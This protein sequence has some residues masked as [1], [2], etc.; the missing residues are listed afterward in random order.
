MG[1]ENVLLSLVSLMHV[2]YSRTE[3]QDAFLGLISESEE[4][5]DKG[6]SCYLGEP[7]ILNCIISFVHY[8]YYSAPIKK[9][10]SSA[11]KTVFLSSSA[12]TLY[13]QLALAL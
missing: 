11:A 4:W 1:F 12:E 6:L 13:L 8:A 7:A 3:Y 2:K 5:I 9:T 10:V